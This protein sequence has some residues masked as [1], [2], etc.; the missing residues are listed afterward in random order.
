[1]KEITL[2]NICGYEEEKV[3]IKKLINLLNNY[4]KYEKEGI[5]IPRGLI[6]QGPPGTGKTLIAK[7]IAGECDYEFYSSFKD[8]FD[9]NPLDTLK[10]VFNE[11]EKHIADTDEPA[12]VYID[13]IDKLVYTERRTGDFKDK[14]ARE[15]ARFLLQKLDSAN[16]KNKLLVIASTNDYSSIPDAL[17]RSGRFDKKLLIDNPDA[18]S[19]KDILR[20]Y[21]NNHP[22][23]KNIDIDKLALKTDGM[24]GADLKTLINN[25]LL[26]YI[27]IKETIVLD[28]FIKV[29]NE[30]NFETIGKKWTDRKANLTILAHEVGHSIVSGILKG[31]WGTI[32]ALSYGNIGGVTCFDEDDELTYPE[33]CNADCSEPLCSKG[34]LR[35]NDVLDDIAISLGGYLGEKILLGY[36]T[37]G[38]VGDLESITDTVEFLMKCGYPNFFRQKNCYYSENTKDKVNKISKK[39]FNKQYRRVYNIIKR[40]KSLGLYLIEEV[41]NNS[42]VLSQEAIQEKVKE[43]MSNKK[44]YNNKY[45]NKKAEELF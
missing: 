19:R 27:T 28:D 13:E 43:F 11:A 3:E 10:N 23:F 45:K 25:T 26:E 12:L 42:D 22:L 1:M 41:H 35:I 14:E 18:K 15:A 17:L 2:S 38:P 39:I 34:V 31:K 16:L 37:T 32:S 20:F 33:E 21:I 24:S 8:D 9:E 40:H 44:K 30:M 36:V 7:A 5:Q 29:I 6:L 4:S